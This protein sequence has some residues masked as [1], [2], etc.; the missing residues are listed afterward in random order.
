M[1]DT[2]QSRPGAGIAFIVAGMIAI[3]I[4]DMLIKQ[5]SGG[6][7]LHQMVFLRSS[8]GIALSMVFVYFEG[9]VSLLKTRHPVLHSVRCIMVVASNMSFFVALAAL[10][11]ADVTALFFAAPLFIT[12]LS[13]PMLGEKVGV[14]R[15][16]AVVIGFAGVILMQRPWEGSDSATADRIVLLLPVLAALTYAIN[17]VMTRKLGATTKASAL[18][19]YIQGMF[20][21]VSI[22]FYLVASDGRYAEGLENPSWVFLLRAWVWPTPQDWYY[23]IGLGLNS[24]IVGYCLAQAYRLSDAA[25][26]APFE[27]IGLPMAVFWGWLFWAEIPSLEVWAGMAMIMGSGLFVF[28]REK[29]KARRVARTEVKG[30]Y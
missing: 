25:T 17:Q 20:I 16:T 6:Y 10:P 19:V 27:Y 1:T 26:V 13:I 8:I 2:T 7:P 24:G 15:L 11:L 30:R 4:N 23:F 9:G 29:Q 28:L 21:L 14:M 12:V 5:L 22:G 18:A 3:S